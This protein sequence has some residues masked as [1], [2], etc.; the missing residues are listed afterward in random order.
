MEPTKDSTFY[1]S[2]LLLKVTFRFLIITTK[3]CEDEPK[4]ETTS[5]HF[6]L[7]SA[8]VLFCGGVQKAV[9]KTRPFAN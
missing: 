3:S 7:L 9:K 6:H 1:M 4:H 8:A 5:A 2:T